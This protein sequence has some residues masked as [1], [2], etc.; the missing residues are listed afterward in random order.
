MNSHTIEAPAELHLELDDKDSLVHYV[1][2]STDK[3]ALCG[4][5][6]SRCL[7]FATADCIVCVELLRKRKLAR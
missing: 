4:A 7:D 1:L 5:E 6:I 2:K 3:K